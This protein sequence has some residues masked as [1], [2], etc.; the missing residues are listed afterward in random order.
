MANITGTAGND[1]LL[2]TS[3]ADSILGMGGN[4]TISGYAGDDSIDGGAGHDALYGN[5]GNNSLS[6]GD[7]NDTLFG[8]TG[9]QTLLG[10]AGDDS[11][12]AGAVS[13]A[14]DSR[15]EGGDG[16][17]ILAV[18]NTGSRTAVVSGGAGVDTI[19][20]TANAGQDAHIRVT[21]FAQ[22][23]GGDMID[24][25]YVLRDLTGYY[26]GN[27]LY[28]QHVRVVQDGADA[29]VEVDLDGTGTVHGFETSL[30]LE[31]VTA[32]G[33]TAWNFRGFP[34]SGWNAMGDTLTGS[35]EAPT[36]RGTIGN[37]WIYGHAGRD[38]L[39]GDGG[40]D[41]IFANEDNDTLDGYLGDD[42]LSGGD[43]NDRIVDRYG[44]NTIYGGAGDDQIGLYGQ[45]SNLVNGNTGNDTFSGGLPG[46][47]HY[48]NGGEGSDLYQLNPLLTG[49]IIEDF[50]GGAG[51]DRFAFGGLI[52][53]F[54]GLAAGANPFSQ[55][56]MRL[57]Q[58]GTDTRL[59]VDFDGAGAA[60][61]WGTL[62][63]FKTFMAGNLTAE[64][65]DGYSA[66]SSAPTS[67]NDT[68]Q[69][70][71]GDDSLSGWGGGDVIYGIAGNDT[72]AGDEGNDTLYG[73]V[74]TDSLSGGAG[75][76]TLYDFEGPSTLRGGDDN[77]WLRGVGSL[78]GGMGNDTVEVLNIDYY[79]PTTLAG[80]GG[81]DIVRGA[82]PWTSQP[83]LANGG[84]GND[85]M[86]IGGYGHTL[87][88]G[89]GEDV[90]EGNQIR[91]YGDDGND[92]ITAGDEATVEGGAGSDTITAFGS[93]SWVRV[94]GDDGDDVITA[95]GYVSVDG[96][97]GN[98]HVTLNAPLEGYLTVE[99]GLGIDTLALGDSLSGADVY[100][101][102]GDIV[103]V[104]DTVAERQANGFEFI[105]QDGVVRAIDPSQFG[106]EIRGNYAADNNLAG[107]ALGDR[108]IGGALDDTLRGLGG[109]D[110]LEDAQGLNL[111]E[112]G[113]GDDR[114]YGVGTMSGGDGNDYI[115]QVGEGRFDVSGGEG[116]D[117]I[118]T[119]YSAYAWHRGPVPSRLD[120][121]AGDD[122]I[123]S[124]LDNVLVTGGDGNDTLMDSSNHVTLEGGDGND[125]I[126]ARDHA[127]GGAGD[128]T[129]SGIGY[130]TLIGG[131]G[132]DVLSMWEARSEAAVISDGVNVIVL[133]K[134]RQEIVTS[135]IE[136]IR[137]SDQTVTLSELGIG[138]RSAGTAG[139]DSLTGTAYTD[140]ISGL[141]GDDTI[142]GGDGV[143]TLDGGDGADVIRG[144]GGFDQIKAGAGAD[145]ADG[146][147]DSDMLDGDAGNDTLLGGAGGDT[148]YGMA[149]DDSLDGGD[150]NDV[151]LANNNY[152]DRNLQTD[153][154]NGGE[155]DDSLYSSSDNG[156]VYGGSGNDWI[157][158]GGDLIDGGDGNDV[159]SL[160]SNSDNSSPTV[161]G[162][163]GDDL[164]SVQGYYNYY[165]L[166]VRASGDTG[167][168]SLL[169]G[170]GSDALNGGVGDD[171][172]F[173]ASRWDTLTG[174]DGND[175]LDG[176]ADNDDMTG[177]VGDDVYFVDHAGD[178]TRE[179]AG[180]GNDTVVSTISW[181]L[182]PDIEALI[183]GGTEDISGTGNGLHNAIE[184]N[185]GANALSGGNGN[186]TL[187]G[188][189][190]DDS[191][192]GGTGS[193]TAVFSGNRTGYAI[194]TD[195]G[196]A[197]VTGADGADVLSGIEWLSFA[198]Q[199]ISLANAPVLGGD[200]AAIVNFDKA[201]VLTTA[202]LGHNDADSDAADI[203]FT[204]SAVKGGKILVDGIEAADFS[205]AELAAGKVSFRHG[206][207]AATAG[208]DVSVSDGVMETA[209]RAFTLSVFDNGD[210]TLTGFDA[211][212]IEL[213]SKNADGEQANDAAYAYV[214]S[215]NGR[216]IVI[217]STASN[218]VADGVDDGR[219][220]LFRKDLVTG[221]VL[222]IDALADGTIANQSGW[223]MDMSDDGN[224]VLF[225]NSSTNLGTPA[226]SPG[227]IQ[228][229]S[230]NMTTGE[231]SVVSTLPGA[232]TVSG[233]YSGALTGDG[234]TAFYT[235]Y[236]YDTP[237][238]V[239]FA[240]MIYVKSLA[241]GS[242]DTL[243]DFNAPGNWTY[244]FAS[245]Y[246]VMPDGG[247][248]LFYS[249]APYITPGDT[250]G[251]ADLFVMDKA[252]GDFSRV[253]V[254]E[255]GAQATAFSLY[256]A[257]MSGDGTKVAFSAYSA[258]L[259]NTGT[260]G[261]EHLFIKDMV[262][263]ELKVI[264]AHAPGIPGSDA[265]APSFS[266][267]GR[268]LYFYSLV[269]NLVAGDTNGK[270]DI[271]AYDVA[272]GGLTRLTDGDGDSSWATAIGND[273]ILFSSAA[274]NLVAN[275]GNGTLDAF[276]MHVT[277]NDSLTGGVGNDRIFGK[278]GDDSLRGEAGS[279]S[280]DGG[281]GNDLLLGGAR[282][283]TLTGGE[284]H[285]TLDG[286][287]E[288][289]A[290]YGGAGNDTYLVN[291]IGDRVYELYGEGTD[292][293]KA[294][295]SYSLT[296]DVENL[297]LT[298]SAVSGTGNG[299]HNAINGN[300]GG[301]VLSGGLGN[302]SLWGWDGNDSLSG[303][304]DHDR[305]SGGNGADTLVGGSG[306][307]VLGGGAGADDFVFASVS[308]NGHDHVGDFEHGVDRLVFSGTDYGFAAG[309]VL[310]A[311]EF[312]VGSAAVGAG[313]QFVW[314]AVAGKLW[315]DADGS[316]A[317][318]AFELALISGGATV[319]KDDLFFV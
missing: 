74:G 229:F 297:S 134:Y 73:G 160:V 195:G 162:G 80:G 31:N 147:A 284:G 64:N 50:A 83:V 176:G 307:D 197:T 138:V 299:L 172:L 317:G 243:S 44:A 116:N 227:S 212:E 103:V 244:Y 12:S 300:S 136:S 237:G 211:G 288:N 20:A 257:T 133:D 67:G 35:A 82:W 290:M 130:S 203:R 254:S 89:D 152:G 261:E 121:G 156:F 124:F 170:A 310:T 185:A 226:G 60:S 295:I 181:S 40:D 270:S 219:P 146:G 106:N 29:V 9:A 81:D 46:V 262:T 180:G 144:G 201:V 10:G 30:V 71:G 95:R 53:K 115:T 264:T 301:N 42:Y 221:E 250:N 22:G 57:T 132:H 274:S 37:D 165:T 16:N 78:D 235:A 131:D 171:S 246:G 315:W 260:A 217:D 28:S 319:T 159:I 86:S 55:G 271:F 126:S 109:D 5:D 304:A 7:G 117:T 282:W 200:L 36:V 11:I 155:G 306:N 207:V 230:K 113:A 128:D 84:D 154:L 228:I 87:R 123:F 141:G 303:G 177:G 157:S 79:N 245:V 191:L 238:P 129:I 293:V 167:N 68:L 70:T 276:V 209:P 98:D 32:S 4:D 169:G 249:D 277:G 139:N 186:D 27:P 38:S 286:G 21:D 242:V 51:G 96:G 272:T 198:N 240:G 234:Q 218:L 52:A 292:T 105:S 318:A 216:Y 251:L 206:G 253:T 173:G 8:Y 314:D 241:D 164:I 158:A 143:D 91:M 168:D 119:A 33:L 298:G 114:L 236:S 48:V 90:L 202:D 175:T 188:G 15:V 166:H 148:L 196:N 13:D 289:D 294:S 135:G 283:D 247:K 199:T 125:S 213:V 108:L 145:W 267:D 224:V 62:V 107:G 204:V 265:Y 275:D 56:Y 231:V 97:A 85:T 311:A 102:G 39:F 233:A 49:V 93:W 24:L 179:L 69:G 163:A 137:F 208:F 150:G 259:A 220:H 255:S 63:T 101:R 3:D 316:G 104:Q 273:R 100:N 183:L 77:D 193:D 194:V 43:G 296:P 305:L 278:G 1:T 268:T 153:T 291:H 266:A 174:G 256:N 252:S 263:G 269:D 75:D 6:G 94:K 2:G 223:V 313:A 285:D 58:S 190:G 92:V 178:R 280:L 309:H 18:W 111:M 149:G 161:T 66:F 151:V 187:T 239:D 127:D 61:A 118:G 308:V 302:D 232:G 210:R 47:I 99:G 222:R 45:G 14:F 215:A 88:G 192:N 225:A 312:T 65:L 23:D 287:S 258:G 184:G 76:D 205:A 120:G 281:T 140:S 142:E 248:V 189:A 26:G 214:A 19:M 17:D 182:A 41:Y 25:Q 59:E 34:Q 110:R 279:D 112:G 72:L 54:T 122:Y